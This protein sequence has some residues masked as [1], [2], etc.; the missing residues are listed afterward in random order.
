[1]PTPIA[2][3][4]IGNFEGKGPKSQNFS[5]ASSKLNWNSQKVGVFKPKNLPRG[6]GYG[7]FSPEKHNNIIY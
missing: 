1:M 2:R 5:K 7:Y 3:R 4:V 6:G